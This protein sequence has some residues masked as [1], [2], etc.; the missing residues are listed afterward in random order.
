MNFYWG[1]EDHREVLRAR[2]RYYASWGIDILARTAFLW[3]SETP[4]VSGPRDAFSVAKERVQDRLRSR[5]RLPAY[6]LSPAALRNN[7]RRMQA[8]RPS[9]LYGMSQA[10]IL[11]AEQALS[12]GD[13]A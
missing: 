1:H 7:L 5:L 10:V 3:G 8:F 12:A 6:D 2:Y 9:M 11:L 13:H 4:L